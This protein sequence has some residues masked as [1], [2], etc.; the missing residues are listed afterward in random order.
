MLQVKAVL[1]GSE[2]SGKTSLFTTYFTGS[3]SEEYVPTVSD[4][5]S[6]EIEYNDAGVTKMVNFSV[7]DTGGLAE[8]DKIRHIS[9]AQANVFLVC[10]SIK[11]R[12][13][14]ESVGKKWI[15]EVRRYNAKA[16]VIL[17]GTMGDIRDDK[18]KLAKEVNLITFQEGANLAVE[19]G[20]ITYIEVSAMREA[21]MDD[22][23]TK[24]IEV[25]LHPVTTKN[26]CCEIIGRLFNRPSI[27]KD[28]EVYSE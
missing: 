23:V 10:F 22:L 16:P 9:Y 24:A 21:G 13:T 20:A 17:V 28:H 5:F 8:Y 15:P 12:K 19:I 11:N 7:W 4:N 27:D 26:S 25:V 6:R 2:G 14:F 1:V 18:K 3:F